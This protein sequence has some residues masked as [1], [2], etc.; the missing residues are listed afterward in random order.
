[1]VS[2]LQW[3]FHIWYRQNTK[4]LNQF[5]CQIINWK[6]IIQKND[7][8]SQI[9]RCFQNKTMTNW[10]ILTMRQDIFHSVWEDFREDM[11]PKYLQAKNQYIFI[12]IIVCTISSLPSLVGFQSHLQYIFWCWCVSDVPWPWFFRTEQKIHKVL[13]FNLRYRFEFFITK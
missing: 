9:H 7:V 2:A 4:L 6:I 5:F 11:R 13:R 1:M 12:L 8:R 3:L 10:T